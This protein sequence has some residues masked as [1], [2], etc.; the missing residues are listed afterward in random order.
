MPTDGV[1]CREFACTGPVVCKVIPVTSAAFSDVTIDQ[2]L[3]A[4]LFPHAL[5][6]GRVIHLVSDT[7]I[8]MYQPVWV[9]NPPR[10]RLT[11][12]LAPENLVSRG[13]FDRPVP[14]QS[15]HFGL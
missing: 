12:H 7:A 2:F 13:G 6:V 15:A 5:W 11:T 14:R 10:S 4:S 3:C 8:F 9:V 1:H